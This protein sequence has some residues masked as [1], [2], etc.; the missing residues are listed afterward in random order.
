MEHL[1]PLKI[2]AV[3]Q[4]ND[5]ETLYIPLSDKGRP[6]L[7]GTG[8]NAAV[9]LARTKLRADSPANYNRAIKFLKNDSDKQYADIIA[10]RFFDEM[11]KAGI[12]TKDQTALVTFFG[13][14]VFG[15]IDK[16]KEHFDKEHYDQ[17][18]HVGDEF[19]NI[20]EYYTLQGPFYVGSCRFRGVGYN[21]IAFAAPEPVIR[22][23]MEVRHDAVSAQHAA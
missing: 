11:T 19:T 2:K 4:A 1:E 3:D 5:I 17:V 21:G 13:K 16:W 23:R 22:L 12:F 15:P 8:R 20:L 18:S 9:F 10:Q 14:G 7:L 6:H